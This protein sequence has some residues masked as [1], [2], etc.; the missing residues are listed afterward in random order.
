MVKHVNPLGLDSKLG[1]MEMAASGDRSQ[2]D[3]QVCI[4]TT[5]ASRIKD[6]ISEAE[7]CE[8]FVADFQPT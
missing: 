7:E 1:D 5:T 4:G 8:I 6:L 3:L 2:K